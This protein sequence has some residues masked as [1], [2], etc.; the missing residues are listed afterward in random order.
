MALVAFVGGLI[1]LDQITK[2][3]IV[4]RF[5]LYERIEVLPVLDITRL[6]NP[7]A[8]FSMLAGAS[9]WQRW[10]FA[11]LALGVGVGIVVWLGKLKARTQGLLAVQPV[12]DP[13]RRAGQ[14]DRPVAARVT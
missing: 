8:A 11:L 14:S 13:G 5:E 2:L 1:V 4:K 10:F 6:H 12:A 3:A 7:G 9:G